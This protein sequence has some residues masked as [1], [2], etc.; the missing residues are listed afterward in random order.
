MRDR[1]PNADPKGG[2]YYQAVSRLVE[3]FGA[4]ILMVRTLR[5]WG[6][7]L[8]GVGPVKGHGSARRLHLGSTTSF[9]LQSKAEHGIC[10]SK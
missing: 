10:R 7:L 8:G 5:T 9:L 3:P 6:H 2:R 1:K 4:L